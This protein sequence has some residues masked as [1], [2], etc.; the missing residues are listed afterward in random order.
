MISIYDTRKRIG[1]WHLLTS[2]LHN[3][4]LSFMQKPLLPIFTLIDHWN[5]EAVLSNA[6]QPCLSKNKKRH[7]Q[8]IDNVIVK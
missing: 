2:N 1:L 8:F 7:F 3:K 5:T 6:N 4:R